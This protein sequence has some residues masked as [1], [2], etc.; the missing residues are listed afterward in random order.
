[1]GGSLTAG[2][3]VARILVRGFAAACFG[4][5]VAA[6]FLTAGFVATVALPADFRA[7]GFWAADF[8]AT[9]VFDLVSRTADCLAASF[10]AVAVALPLDFP[11]VTGLRGDEREAATFCVAAF[12]AWRFVPELPPRAA[13]GFAPRSWAAF[14]RDTLTSPRMARPDDRPFAA[15]FAVARRVDLLCKVEAIGTTLV[16]VVTW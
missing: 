11:A 9:A 4:V 8:L 1:L 5:V 15:A 7:T 10:L 12:V 2:C 16:T 3:G 6:G 14:G 13:F